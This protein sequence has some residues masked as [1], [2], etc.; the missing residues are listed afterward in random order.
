MIE[1]AVRKPRQ[2]EG[3]RRKLQNSIAGRLETEGIFRPC[4][5]TRKHLYSIYAKMRSKRR[6]FAEIMDV[7]AFRIV[8]DDVDTCYRVLG[9]V[10]NLYA[11]P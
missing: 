11:S 10:H 1:K 9:M 5:W 7:Y 8:V 2:S 3:G 4:L 6:S